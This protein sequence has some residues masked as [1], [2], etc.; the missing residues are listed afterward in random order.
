MKKKRKLLA[1]AEAAAPTCVPCEPPGPSKKAKQKADG[2][3]DIFAVL[4]GKKAARDAKRRA[5]EEEEALEAAE[6]EA[7]AAARP[8]MERD[9]IF[10]EEYDPSA[11]VDPMSARVHRFD[12]QSGYNVY[13]AH[14]LGLGRGGGTPACPFDCMCCF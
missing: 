1:A 3:D 10:G 9:P 12:N 2:L 8:R 13:K 7:A 4:P 11:R 14:A 6:A 5:R